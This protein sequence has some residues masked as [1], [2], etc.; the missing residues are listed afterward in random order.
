MDTLA[1]AAAPFTV[2]RI[3]A[4]GAG[5]VVATLGSMAFDWAYDHGPKRGNR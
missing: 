5:L 1:V 3:V 2:A 4:T